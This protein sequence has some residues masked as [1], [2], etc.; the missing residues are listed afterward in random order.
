MLNEWSIVAFIFPLCSIRGYFYIFR[1]I[2]WDKYFWDKSTLWWNWYFQIGFLNSV[3]VLSYL[4]ELQEIPR[5]LP[6]TFL[7][8]QSKFRKTEKPRSVRWWLCLAQSCQPN[9][10]Q[11]LS[12]PHL[13]PLL[14]ITM[15][16]KFKSG[17]QTEKL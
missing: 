13:P 8:I 4:I 9:L 11:S 6:K 12:L 17:F 15:R 1:N 16:R 5:Y 10:L 14:A 7:L 2:C 3:H